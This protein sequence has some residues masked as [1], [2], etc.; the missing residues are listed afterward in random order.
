MPPEEPL[1]P[2]PDPPRE[3]GLGLPMPIIPIIQN[4]VINPDG[5]KFSQQYDRWRD[6]EAEDEAED[7]VDI[8]LAE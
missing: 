4:G 8:T 7:L 1:T 3:S 2:T 5:L 6:T